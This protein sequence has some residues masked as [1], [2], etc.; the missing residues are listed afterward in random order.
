MINAAIMAHL[1]Y[2]LLSASTAVC[3]VGV[4]FTK[5]IIMLMVL[6]SLCSFW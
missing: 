6:F 2:I 5:I 1:Y 3:S 4:N